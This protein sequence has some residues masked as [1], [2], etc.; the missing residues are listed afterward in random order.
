MVGAVALFFVG[1]LEA[2]PLVFIY[3]SCLMARPKLGTLKLKGW[4]K[5]RREWF[6]SGLPCFLFGQDPAIV[7]LAFTGSHARSPCCVADK[8]TNNERRSSGPFTDAG[9]TEQSSG[10]T[11]GAASRSRGVARA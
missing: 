6:T 5:F 1:D 3:T 2:A 4:E 10:A 11:C 7:L 8:Q 9:R